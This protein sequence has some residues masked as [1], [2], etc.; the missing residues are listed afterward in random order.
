MPAPVFTPIS[1]DKDD[2]P[3]DSGAGYMEKWIALSGNFSTL[4]DYLAEVELTVEETT[5]QLVA[6]T[7]EDRAAVEVS[8][9]GAALILAGVVA[10][11]RLLAQGAATAANNSANAAAASAASAAVIADI[12]DVSKFTVAKSLARAIHLTA[13]S[14]AS[15]GIQI[16]SNT[17]N[18][19]GLDDFTPIW[20]GALPD[21]TPSADV[22][23]LRKH[24]GTNGYILSI[25][26][27][28]VIRLQLNGF[29]YDSTVAITTVVAD[30]DDV[31]IDVPITRETATAAGSVRF[32]VNGVQLGAAVTINAAD[33]NLEMIQ[34]SS[35]DDTTGWFSSVNLGASSTG[36]SWVISSGKATG[37][38]ADNSLHD[39]LLQSQGAL[40]YGDGTYDYTV[41]WENLT[42]TT[43]ILT[44]TLSIGTSL[45]TL[46][47]S[48][49][50]ITVR[51][52]MGSSSAGIR[53]Y[54]GSVDILSVSAK[55]V[56]NA[57]TTVSLYLMGT[58][59]T[60]TAGKFVEAAL[61]NRSM[62]ALDSLRRV[63]SG[64]DRSDSTGS[65]ERILADDFEADVTGWNRNGG[66]SITH[67]TSTPISG[68]GSLKSSVTGSNYI[69]GASVLITG[70]LRQ[71]GK[72]A[73]RFKYKLSAAGLMFLGID[74]PSGG[75]VERT[76]VSGLTATTTTEVYQEFTIPDT[77]GFSG[78]YLVFWPA[79]NAGNAFDYWLDDL[80]IWEIG[81]VARYPAENAQSDTG[82]IFDDSGNKQHGLLPA[83]R[84]TVIGRPASSPQQVRW[85]NS[86]AETHELQYIGGVNQPILPAKTHILSIVGVITTTGGSGVQDIIVGDGSDTD[87]YVA[88]TTG[89]AAGTKIFTLTG[90]PFT[91]GTNLKLTVDPDATCTMSI[92]WTIT[93]TTLD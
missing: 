23:L 60:T 85:T 82:Q 71:G 17:E 86:W 21:Y 61:Y 11:D 26:T 4:A 44:N 87:R 80:E 55:L 16:P 76:I 1:F 93:F 19:P 29:T 18:N 88:I 91:D 78:P 64:V 84:A 28:G 79:Y 57:T 75:A 49:G 52:K 10:P 25:R 92:T 90:T 43:R 72:Y 39:S 15:T 37:T 32:N 20:Q 63:R 54:S 65:N 12:A 45:R 56:T 9:A 74:S 8:I 47:G 70:L 83:S 38:F 36:L 46:S 34:N 53:V 67:D 50:T 48:S 73:A 66:G 62:S 14:S 6:Q 3:Y 31:V 35:F 40:P 81:Q 5:A 30:Y 27:T 13:A 59:T 7:A 69:G 58:S 77:F 42:G 89:L 41:V 2:N 51:G 33:P 24:D 68:A 22:I